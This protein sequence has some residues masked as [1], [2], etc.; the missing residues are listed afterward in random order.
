M[1]ECFQLR[2]FGTFLVE[3]P[4]GDVLEVFMVVGSESINM[5]PEDKY[6]R[7]TQR[8]NYDNCFIN[9]PGIKLLIFAITHVRLVIT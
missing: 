6:Q 9:G 4:L 5:P 1:F 7:K 3:L 8:I 2:N